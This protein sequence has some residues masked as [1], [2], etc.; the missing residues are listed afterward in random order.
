MNK[1]WAIHDNRDYYE[2]VTRYLE[3]PPNVD[4][5][6]EHTMYEEEWDRCRMGRGVKPKYNNFADWLI[7]KGCWEI[8]PYDEEIEGD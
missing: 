2:C 8:T 4:V 7:E 6:A 3:V 5:K 1:V